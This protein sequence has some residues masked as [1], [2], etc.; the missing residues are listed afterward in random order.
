MY[1]SQS[2]W[3]LFQTGGF[4][5]LWL[6]AAWSL[7]CSQRTY[8]C[9]LCFSQ[10]AGRSG[11]RPPT[12]CS[13]CCEYKVQS[14]SIHHR[15]SLRLVFSRNIRVWTKKDE[16]AANSLITPETLWALNTS[17]Y[18]LNK[19]L[20]AARCGCM[21]MDDR[22]AFSSKKTKH[23]L[24]VKFEY[25]LNRTNVR[26][27]MQMRKLICC[28]NM[29]DM[30]IDINEIRDDAAVNGLKWNVSASY[31]YL[32][33]ESNRITD[34]IPSQCFLT[35]SRCL[36]VNIHLV[37][38][39]NESS[40]PNTVLATTVCENTMSCLKVETLTTDKGCDRDTLVMKHCP[41]DTLVITLIWYPHKSLPLHPAP[42]C[43]PLLPFNLF[44]WLL[45]VNCSA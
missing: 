18:S 45:G 38:V 11:S 29:P 17:V 12:A 34:K 32:S 31:Q 39:S 1:S 36:G 3:L 37:P 44:N 40:H 19:C 2:S 13:C 10:L 4:L 15:L 35:Y 33:T 9:L 5:C 8:E 25:W 41:D 42:S 24:L 43:C 20:L 6:P 30:I 21:L 14:D 28:K 27:W 23:I 22:T 7:L 16:A 26:L